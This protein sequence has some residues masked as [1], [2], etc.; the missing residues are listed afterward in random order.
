MNS[1]PFFFCTHFLFEIIYPVHHS[2]LSEQTLTP[3]PPTTWIEKSRSKSVS[4]RL[5]ICDVDPK[6]NSALRRRLIPRLTNLLDQY[7]SGLTPDAEVGAVVDH[8]PHY[9]TYK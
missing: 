3:D 8:L 1:I 5:Y 7:F 6:N 4:T 2:P 9:G